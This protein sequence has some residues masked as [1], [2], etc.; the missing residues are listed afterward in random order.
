MW[1][2]NSTCGVVTVHVGVVTV[3]VVTMH[4]GW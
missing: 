1:G 4:V 3:H 2:G